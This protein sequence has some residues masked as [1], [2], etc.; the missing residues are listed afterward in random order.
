MQ[1]ILGLFTGTSSADD[2]VYSYEDVVS[3][4]IIFVIILY[5]ESDRNSVSVSA[6]APKL[7]LLVVSAWFRLRP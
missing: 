4:I 1:L 3:F 6:T 2:D 5:I 7:T